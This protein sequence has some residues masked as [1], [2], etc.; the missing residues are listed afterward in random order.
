MLPCLHGAKQLLLI[1]KGASEQARSGRAIKGPLLFQRCGLCLR[2]VPGMMLMQREESLPMLGRLC[3]QVPDAREKAIAAAGLSQ[4]VYADLQSQTK[5]TD[6]AYTV[7]KQKPCCL[8]LQ[9]RRIWDE[10]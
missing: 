9:V 2:M 1:A 6:A 3:L 7:P 4:A 8:F 5:E 10:G